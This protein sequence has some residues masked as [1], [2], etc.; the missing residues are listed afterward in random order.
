MN[1]WKATMPRTKP[2][3]GKVHFVMALKRANGTRL[4]LAGPLDE[5]G[6]MEVWKLAHEVSARAIK[7]KRDAAL[8]S[9]EG[10]TAGVIK[11]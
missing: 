10:A 8:A 5:A 9:A 4:E 11:P 1:E 3:A 7:A 2:E 6:A